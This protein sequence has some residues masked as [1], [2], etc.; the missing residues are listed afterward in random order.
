MLSR[1]SHDTHSTAF[2]IGL[3]LLAVGAILAYL[4]IGGAL[5]ENNSKIAVY[6]PQMSDGAKPR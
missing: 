5:T 6:T 2:P 3:L 4:A 1:H